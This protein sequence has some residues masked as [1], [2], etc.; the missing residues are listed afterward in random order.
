MVLEDEEFLLS[1]IKVKVKEED[2]EMC[3]SGITELKIET[4]IDQLK[5]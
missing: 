3:E 2:K 1:K 5:N 4:A